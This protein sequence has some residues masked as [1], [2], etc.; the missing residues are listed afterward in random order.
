MTKLQPIE[1]QG[2]QTYPNPSYAIRVSKGRKEISQVVRE[3][4]WK[5][6]NHPKTNTHSLPN[7]NNK[8]RK[9]NKLPPR[10]RLQSRVKNHQRKKRIEKRQI[11]DWP[12]CGGASNGRC[13]EF[14]LSGCYANPER[15]ISQGCW[16]SQR[17]ES[18]FCQ[19]WG[20]QPY[21]LDTRWTHY[22]WIILDH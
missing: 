22:Y 12:R 6:R 9:R 20:P 5:E 1:T 2:I 19:A 21:K 11:S 15:P 10:N 14:L 4:K 8:T 13:S 17:G 3:T 18:G 7:T 16:D